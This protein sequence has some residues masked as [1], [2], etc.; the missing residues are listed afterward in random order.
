[1]HDCIF[2]KIVSNKIPSI[3]L[4]EDKTSL[5]IAPK[6]A[7]SKGHMLIISKK[8]YENIFDIPEEE[9][10][11]IMSAAKKIS[12]RLKD[13][14]DIKGINILHASGKAAQ[15]SV[16]HFH[17]HLI[18]RFE[19]DGVDAWPKFKYEDKNKDEI[20]REIRGALK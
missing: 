6:E 17:I 11:K 20:Y 4:F 16:L 13:K 7:E 18:P 12:N 1:M 2:C 9:L 19:N 10:N 14:W 3:K 15:Q 5:V 8:H